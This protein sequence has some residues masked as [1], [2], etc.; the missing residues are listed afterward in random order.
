MEKATETIK[1]NGAGELEAREP[2]A[3]EPVTPCFSA[4]RADKAELAVRT[5]AALTMG[6]GFRF[7]DLR[8][9]WWFAKQLAASQFVPDNYK[10]RP[11]DCLVAMDLA[12]RLRASPLA[13]LQNSYSVRGRPGLEAKFVVALLNNSGLFA[14]PLEYEIVGDDPYDNAFKVRAYAQRKETGK[15]AFGPWITWELVKS[16]GWYDK[17]GSKW[18]TIPDVMFCYRAA[19]WFANRHCPGVTCGMHTT[20]ELEDMGPKRI[21]SRDLTPTN[22]RQPFGFE[23]GSPAPNASNG[24]PDASE[25]AAQAPPAALSADRQGGQAV[26]EAECIKCGQPY[27]EKQKKGTPCVACGSRLGYRTVSADRQA[28]AEQKIAGTA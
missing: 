16:E 12:A 20:D 24:V 28:V 13:V 19:A 25:V 26:P 1:K 15:I 14:G 10:G 2:A 21:E 5:P 18:K 8:E 6:E 17:P 4:D 9:A 11:G 27:T 23:E 7:A 3:R 22:G